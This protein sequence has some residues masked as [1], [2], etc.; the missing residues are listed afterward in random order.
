MR[1][2]IRDVRH[3][4]QAG[5]GML[6]IC[7]RNWRQLGPPFPGGSMHFLSR[8]VGKKSEMLLECCRE[9]SVVLVS[10]CIRNLTYRHAPAPKQFKRVSHAAFRTVIEHSHAEPR[11]KGA[12][13]P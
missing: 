7:G 11:F 10:H 1:H 6:R 4:Y 13:E 12:L 3:Y 9:T 8:L 2:S 5:S